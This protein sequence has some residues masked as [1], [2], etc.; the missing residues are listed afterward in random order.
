MTPALLAVALTVCAPALKDPPPDDGGLTGRWTLESITVAGT[1]AA[2]LTLTLTLSRDGRF[3]TRLN[4]TVVTGTYRVNRTAN[5]PEIET[6]AA[7]A[8]R[9]PQT[10]RGIYKIDADT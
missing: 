10:T 6:V 4:D 8:G 3:E 2:D 7:S 1:K 9:Q 5:P